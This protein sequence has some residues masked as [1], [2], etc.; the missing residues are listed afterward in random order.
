MAASRQVDANA[1]C[2]DTTALRMFAPSEMLTSMTDADNQWGLSNLG[3]ENLLV[4]LEPWAEEFVIPARSNI[5][6]KPSGKSQ[7]CALGDIEWTADHLVIWASARTVEVFIDGVLQE[8]GSAVIPI[9]DG[10]TKEM[11][12]IVFAGQPSARLGGAVSGVLER[13]PWWRR[14]MRRWGL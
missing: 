2:H 7:D 5:V 4:W 12:N 13:T 8:S 1:D 6:L 10:L 14:V 9:P 11:L 3:P